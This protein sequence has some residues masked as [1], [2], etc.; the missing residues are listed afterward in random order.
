MNS[1]KQFKQLLN[2]KQLILFLLTGLILITATPLNA[3]TLAPVET[4]TNLDLTSGKQLN[5]L[6]VYLFWGDGCPHC[7]AEI[8]FLNKIQKNYPQIEF[9]KFEIY[10]NQNNYKLLEQIS[11]EKGVEVKGVPT[12]FIGDQTIIGFNTEATTGLKIKRA[13]DNYLIKNKIKAPTADKKNN[14]NKDEV[15]EH[16]LMGKINLNK[17][18]LP[19]LTAILGTLDGFN[20]CSMWALIVLITLLINSGSRKKMWLVGGIFIIAS[21]ASYF[22]FL[23]AWLN[24]F[25]LIGYIKIVRLLIGLLAIGVGIYFLY[26][27]YKNRSKNTITCEVSNEQTKDKIIKKLEKVINKKSLWAIIVGVVTV[28]FSVNLIELMCSAGIPA[29]YTQIL[30]QNHLSRLT[31]YLY[32]LVYDFFY[33]L[34][35]II[36]LLVA[37][38]T[39]Q[40]LQGTQKYTKY[41][42]L[43]GGALILILGIIM[44]VNPGLLSFK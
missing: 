7:H 20:P 41:S 4:K 21:A 27:A 22:L 42:H 34:D 1:I 24:A 25:L 18:S 28:A 30:S 39:W 44:I 2:K 36:V 12:L 8:I 37:G 31:Y 14:E 13:L 35:D 11:R 26:D 3:K 9:K 5:K 17:L 38:I 23:T 43:I 6:P 40:L 32:L 16:P 15:I 29:I 10:N 33:M 19:V